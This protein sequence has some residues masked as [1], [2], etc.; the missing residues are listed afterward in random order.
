[1]RSSLRAFDL[2]KFKT[3]ALSLPGRGGAAFTGPL[4]D[5]SP[6]NPWQLAEESHLEYIRDNPGDDFILVE[7]IVVEAASFAP[8]P[9]LSGTLDGNRHSID[10][11]SA[12]IE[13]GSH[14]GFFTSIGSAGVVKYLGLFGG[15]VSST[16]G[17]SVYK[18]MIAGINSGVL[19][20]C[21]ARNG[22]VNTSGDRAGGLVGYNPGTLRKCYAVIT[23]GGGSSSRTGG[24]TGFSDGTYDGFSY[25]NSDTWPGGHGTGG[26]SVSYT[27]AQMKNQ[28]NYSGWDFSTLWTT[29]GATTYPEYR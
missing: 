16:G 15:T 26:S 25:F 14:T 28:N 17:G 13:G 22:T 1:M 6:G 23:Q 4:G 27:T 8:L 5:G 10:L 7:D 20:H 24:I 19:E 11:G 9:A 18:G 29:N 3:L 12:L 21:F 2:N